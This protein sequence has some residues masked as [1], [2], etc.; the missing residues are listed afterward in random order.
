MYVLWK[1]QLRVQSVIKAL[2]K[3]V[4]G[5]SCTLKKAGDDLLVAQQKLMHDRDNLVLIKEI[6]DRTEE[7]FKWSEIEEHILKQRI[8]V[9]HVTEPEIIKALMDIGDL[10]Y[11][12]IDGFGAKFYKASLS[13][14]KQDIF[15]VVMDFFVNDRLYAT[16]NITLVTLI[17]KGSVVKLSNTICK[18]LDVP[19]YATFVPRLNIH[20]HILLAYE[21][22]RSYSRKGGTPRCMLK[23]DIKKDYD[24]V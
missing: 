22:I 19:L 15:D 3:P 14:V 13:T 10:K 8:L 20:D 16:F 18:S 6:K 9:A 4:L 24:T 2:S 23:L 17:P 21:L 1:K 11:P 12:S 5:A 7:V